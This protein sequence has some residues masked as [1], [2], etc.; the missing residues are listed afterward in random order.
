MTQSPHRIDPT[1]IDAYRPAEIA[2]RIEESGLAKAGLPL[3]QLVLLSI[4]AGAF[5]ALGAA[6]YTAVMTG[7]EPGFGAARLLGGVVFSTGLILV[8]VAGAEL[9]TGNALI[10]MATPAGRKARS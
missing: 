1:G 8:I 7:A 4:L 9:F 3:V 6:A 10:V 5:I 2:R